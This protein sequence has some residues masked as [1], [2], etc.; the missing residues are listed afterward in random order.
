MLPLWH[1]SRCKSKAL[2]YLCNDRA[3]LYKGHYYFAKKI[4]ITGKASSFMVGEYMD[5]SK[6]GG[7][8]DNVKKNCRAHFCLKYS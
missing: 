2:H 6:T 3:S 8:T 4:T 1:I 5:K 7:V